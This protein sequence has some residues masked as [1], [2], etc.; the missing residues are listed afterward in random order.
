L[1][2]LL[3]ASSAFAFRDRLA[4]AAHWFRSAG[5]SSGGGEKVSVFQV[6]VDH[7]HRAW[8]DVL[9]DRPLGQG[10]QGEVIDP[11]PATID[12]AIGGFWKWQDSNALRF[13]PSGGF[14]M[15][16]EY[17]L[18]L[19]PERLLQKG[20]VWN[21]DTIFKVSTERFVV[22]GVDLHEEPAIEGK[23]KVTFRGTLKFS[24]R[25]HPEV[26]A[27]KLKL[28]DS[29]L[30]DDKPIE[31]NLETHYPAQQIL[32]HTGTVQ[33][34]EAERKLRLTIAKELTP[35]DGNVALGQDFVQEVPL[36]SSHSL[37]VWDVNSEPG[38]KES[39]IRIRVS[40]PVA[41][42]VVEKY[43]KIT[44]EVKYHLSAESNV[45]TLTGEF[46][47]GE[48]YDLVLGKGMPATDDA[49]LGEDWKS[50]VNLADLQPAAG[51]Q[52]Q[53][54]F[55]S[56]SGYHTVA[57]ESV[58][59]S[60]V[61]LTIDR[62]YR[63]NLFLLF[64]YGNFS[65]GEQTWS[66]SQIEHALGD[67]V[68]DETLKLG[69]PKN[70][71]VLTP[72]TLDRHLKDKKPG[73]Y[74]VVVSRE[75]K[76]GDDDDEYGGGKAV[77]RWLLL[78]DLG[79]V[80]KHGDGEFLVWVASFK[81]LAP[82]AGA[83][84]TVLSDQNQTLGSGKTDESGL[85]RFKDAKGLKDQKPYMV[86]IEKGDDL[87]FLLLDQM[88]VDTSGLD[89]AGATPQT[90]GYT[91][92]LYGERDIYRPGER[93]EG[94]AVVRDVRLQPAPRMPLLLRWKDP[95]GRER[96]TQ[97]IT[98][99]ERGLATFHL[100]LPGY[101]LTGN[102][103][104]EL[105]V[106]QDVVGIYRF[107][108]EEFVPDR[109]K[110]EI[111]KPATAVG[112]GKP[113]DYT[114]ASAYLFGP[115]AA[116]LPV[117][118]R[119][120][121][122]DASFNPKGYEGFTFR[123][124]E[125]KIDDR[126]VLSEEGTLDDQGR[127]S[128]QATMPTGAPVPSALEAIVTAR[129]QEQGGR[130]VAAMARVPV[131]P[132]PYYLGIKRPKEG[133]GEPGQPNELE[134]VAVTPEGKPATAG[135]LR[136]ELFRDR[137]NTVWRKTASG[138]YTYESTRDPELVESRSIGGGTGKGSFQF[139][140]RQFGS[141]RA[142]LT[143]PATQASTEVE[144][145]A[146]GYGYSPWAL[147]NPGRLD[148][149][150]DKTEYA[151]GETA[152]VQVR[153][154]FAGKLL[155]TVERSGVRFTK[156]VTLTGN[157]ATIPVPLSEEDRPN[158]YITAT[159]VRPVGDLEP[160]GVARAFGAVPVNVDR[161]ANRLAPTIESPAEMRP[162]GKLDLAIKTAP[163]A[164]VTVAAVDEGILQL[165]DQ[166]TA[167]PFDF[168]YRKLALG[169]TAFDSWSVL[170][171]EVKPEGKAPAGG[172]EGKDGLS[173]HV[174]TAGIRRVQPV[175]FW[176]GPLIADAQGVAH[177]SFNVPEFQ[178]ALRI[179][180]VSLDGRRFGSAEKLTRIRDP[181]VL[182]PT[183]PRILSFQESLQVP[184]T[185]RNDTG[186]D[187]S[188][189][190]AL[191]AQGPVKVD[192]PAVQ[193]AAV[194][195]G[196]EKTVY[197]TVKTGEAT[198]DASFVLTGE[199][200]G[201][202]TKSTTGVPVRPDLPAIA[203]EEAGAVGKETLDLPF[204]NQSRYR[205]ESVI[206]ELRVGPL[207]IVQFTGKLRYLLRYPYGCLEQTTSTSF[208]MLY[209]G[210][211]AKELDPALFK[212][213]DPAERVQ[214]GLQRISGMQLFGGGFSLWPGGEV[215]HPWGTVYAT[216]FLVE[217]RR[218][219]HPVEDYLH[220]GA[221][222][223]LASDVKAKSAYG[224]DELERVVYE[225]YVLARAGKADLGTMD[226]LRQKHYAE[227]SQDSRALLAGAYAA[228]GN[229]PAVA[230]LTSTL[231][232]VE[233]V[234]RQ[235]G[236]N[237]NS[238][239]RNRAIVLL[240]L[241][242]AKPDSPVV[243]ALVDRLARDA[244]EVPEWT[245]QE[246]GWV[247]LALGQFIKHQAKQPAYSGTA[248][249]GGKKIGTFTN[250]TATFLDLKGDGAVRIQMNGGYATGSAFFSLETRGI[251]TDEAFAP[252]HNGLEIERM[253][254][255]RT[256]KPFDLSAVQQGDLLVLKI[257]VRSVAGPVQNV[258][259]ENLLPSGLEVEN[260]RLSTTE[261]LP[262]VTDANNTIDYLDLRDDRILVFTSLPSNSWVSFYT[263]ARAVAPGKFRLPPIHAE[264]MY[265][266]AFQATAERGKIE[267][268][269]R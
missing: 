166:K 129:V 116:G 74:R 178:G 181:L 214:L 142:V 139:T 30:G 63:N 105:L 263:L 167:Q 206:R 222:K 145:Y 159:L 247:F 242:D 31:I 126:E 44:P 71:K 39:T 144:F 49:V 261:T 28:I 135:G 134:W 233:Q 189:K 132:Y 34:K 10:K 87:S 5:G 217:A 111:A 64:Q 161:T 265:N 155:L 147:K 54:M 252:S 209:L 82:A 154:P 91:A 85:F 17:S 27:P 246:S 201:Q 83:R 50:R 220:D 120:R 194:P 230:A 171:P 262:W 236:G 35:A 182:L 57:L 33:K 169:V 174:R 127:K 197:F 79:A 22:E 228:V 69:H 58:N 221:L 243:P 124:A 211:L 168:F 121:L 183:F 200:N 48:G 162:N 97:K 224:A 15:A 202:S 223:Y 146:E 26:L 204:A 235:T 158:A 160:G 143:D 43:L 173:Q 148:L 256:G 215:V 56:A 216:H 137:W 239:I 46:R 130:G 62:V 104:L 73:L 59:V 98:G 61:R 110:V 184:V 84:V 219:G 267:V 170:L 248:W 41:A 113:L 176:S 70:R 60:K 196:R 244:R 65:E 257:R 25:V 40:S 264:A 4:A 269:V 203:V 32:F 66:G 255:D 150:L 16:S 136:A 13:F 198:G 186:K 180:A 107:H 131:H 9:F 1:S 75:G 118:T 164:V 213:G 123:N 251:P 102:H 229:P 179:M 119:V 172:G 163:G 157:T 106:G 72:L 192:G 77:Q 226:F 249:L 227:L 188:F 90:A 100:D 153:A 42:G 141:Y 14:P 138:S 78:T 210:D 38:D 253:V 232:K 23:G 109:I 195:V 241:L 37:A 199:G 212:K 19:L 93:L 258:V 128:F 8:V 67:R 240:A 51:F 112:P 7:Q 101:A 177:A 193:T 81:T 24:V 52:S 47:P 152:K 68:D 238:T 133:Y 234:E 2:V 11:P 89:V 36:G 237:F 149:D 125:R 140:P 80:A 165:I 115:P 205:P 187:G 12:P 114:V 207:P 99:D 185:V 86:T 94:L 191:N 21:G 225:L 268:K 175:A 76:S 208:P 117:E 20:Q 151:P 190:I 6:N 3:L 250:K 92:Y 266:P 103:T 108:V 218:A 122:V 254:L 231:G 88:R 29:D 45:I 53:G 260:P 259:V 96:G 156:V 95:Q 18:T 245:T 55:L